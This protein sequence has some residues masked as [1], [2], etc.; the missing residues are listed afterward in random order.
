MDCPQ[1][2]AESSANLFHSQPEIQTTG[3]QDV[4][5]GDKNLVMCWH[6][7]KPRYSNG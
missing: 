3:P 5:K 2:D 6:D 7:E 4:S 1:R